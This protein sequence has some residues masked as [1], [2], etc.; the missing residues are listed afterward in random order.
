MSLVD[1][2]SN[3]WGVAAFGVVALA[4]LV[5][6]VVNRIIWE[7]S[8]Q[9]NSGPPIPERLFSYDA[10]EIKRFADV[11]RRFAIGHRNAL[12]FYRDVI[13]RR[14]DIG[15][16]IA[17]ASTTAFI[18]FKLA[19]WPMPF[20][21][22]NWIAVPLGS[23]AILYGIADVA[24]DLKLASIL[25]HPD[26]IDRAEAAA[27]NMLTRI[28]IISLSLSVVGVVIFLVIQVFERLA[29]KA[30]PREPLE[31]DRPLGR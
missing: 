22:M 17:L 6:G 8:A 31:P 15:F 14:S 1:L 30:L 27:T 5:W 21:L 25:D 24:E 19:V 2:L 28:K 9:R 16:A 4:A 29:Q 26:Q 20:A 23:M 18:C 12:A 13:L 7:R 3:H 11:A 10:L